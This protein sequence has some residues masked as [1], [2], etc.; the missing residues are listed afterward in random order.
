MQSES[1]ESPTAFFV[2]TFVVAGVIG[3]VIAWLGIAGQ[4]GWGVP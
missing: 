4:L 3:V 1:R 2:V